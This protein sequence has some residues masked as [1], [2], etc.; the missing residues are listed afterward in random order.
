MIKAIIF[1]FNRTLYDPTSFSLFPGVDLFLKDLHKT[2][3]LYLISYGGETRK[4][5]ISSLGITGYFN[6]VKVVQNKSKKLFLQII[7]S[8]GF[9]AGEFVV[10]GDQINK[11]ITIGKETGAITILFRPGNNN[12]VDV[13]DFV[14]ST[15]GEI[16]NILRVK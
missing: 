5:L 8:S 7:G 10:I 9:N 12:K 6:A 11:E 13:A 14:V 1:D 15:H 2:H 3:K 16:K 4:R